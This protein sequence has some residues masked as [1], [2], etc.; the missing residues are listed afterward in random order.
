M[1]TNRPANVNYVSLFNEAKYP[2]MLLFRKQ[3][4]VLGTAYI[5]PQAS[6]TWLI[7]HR[8]HQAS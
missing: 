6:T 3:K 1:I 4:E 7:R 8:Q 2:Q 5:P